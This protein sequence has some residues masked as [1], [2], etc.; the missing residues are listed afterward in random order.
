MLDCAATEYDTSKIHADNDSDLK[1]RYG[2][3]E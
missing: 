2:P 3:K 1:Y